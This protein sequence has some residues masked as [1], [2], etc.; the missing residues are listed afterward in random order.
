[1]EY[2][3]FLI[4]QLEDVQKNLSS[5]EETTEKKN[6]ASP[7]HGTRSYRVIRGHRSKREDSKRRI[8]GKGLGMDFPLK[9]RSLFYLENACTLLSGRI[10]LTKRGDRE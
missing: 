8:R 9:K 6:P 2:P 10:C 7:I 1:V 5:K 3:A 4:G